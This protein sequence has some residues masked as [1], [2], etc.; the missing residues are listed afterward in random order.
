MHHSALKAEIIR[1][2]NCFEQVYDQHCHGYYEMLFVL[3]G[4]IRLNVEGR[5]VLLEKNAGIMMEP[6]TYHI[7]TGNNTAYDRLILYIERDFIPDIIRMQ[8]DEKLTRNPVF[9]SRTLAGL[10]RKY[11]AA[12]EENDPVYAPLLDAIL[13]EVLYA[14]AFDDRETGRSLDSKRTE[15][16]QQIVAMIDENLHREIGLEEI[17]SR[18]YMSQ[19]SLCHLFREEMKIPLKQYI[20]QKKMAYARALL[21]EGATPGEAAN[22]CG[23]K[24]Y[25]S[26]YKI[27][28]KA[29]GKT[30]AQISR[31]T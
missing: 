22:A 14:L 1:T 21:T 17:A 27:F 18:L 7:V 4:S 28:L 13:T 10:L 8:L 20:L 6:L 26:F 23:Y 29:I 25:A 15:K 3:N 31:E 11:A 24:N 5:H 30:P 2:A 12:L 9:A 19:S 16:L